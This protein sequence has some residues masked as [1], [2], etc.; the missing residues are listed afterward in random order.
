MTYSFDIA[1]AQEYG[2]NA[3]IMIHNFQFWIRKHRAENTN[4]YDGRYWTYNSVRGWS[5]L[6]CFWTPKQIRN[7]LDNLIDRGVLKK[8][9]YNKNPYD[10]TLWYAFADEEKWVGPNDQIHLP[11]RANVFVQTGQPIPDIKPDNKPENNYNSAR[12]GNVDCDSRKSFAS[13][14]WNI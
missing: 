5:E 4:Y 11:K 7:I 2:V 9:N 10:R 1:V 3:A 6:F 12:V 13:A 14:L 8:S